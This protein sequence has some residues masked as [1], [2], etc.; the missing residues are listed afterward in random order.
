MT[1]QEIIEKWK[2]GLSKNQLALIYKRQYNMEIKL[3]RLNMQNR[4][5]GKLISNYEALQYVEKIIYNEVKQENN[6]I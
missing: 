6:D 3:I 4:H 2:A 1:K 5:S